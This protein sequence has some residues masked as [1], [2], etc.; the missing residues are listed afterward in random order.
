V[1]P[2]TSTAYPLRTLNKYL[3]CVEAEEAV[4]AGGDEAC[5]ARQTKR[6]PAKARRKCG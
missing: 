3:A 5:S 4:E 6:I 2:L 1:V